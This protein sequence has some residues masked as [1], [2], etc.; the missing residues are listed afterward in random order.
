M[1]QNI[2]FSSDHHLD[3]ANIIKLCNRPFENV[4]QMN[5]VLI[6]NINKHIKSD[7]KFYLLGDFAHANFVKTREFRRKIEC[8]KIHFIMG[9]H[10][11]QSINRKEAELIF[12]TVD[13]LTEFRMNKRKYVLCHYPL[14]EWNGKRNGS[15][16]LHGHNHNNLSCSHKFGYSNGLILDVGVDTNNFVPYNLDEINL[17]M[18]NKYKLIGR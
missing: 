12:G 16:C 2:W 11:Y 18:D 5:D 9:N 3:H 10:D 13:D 8:K 1:A 14:K 4:N 7:D 17:I 15:V 6:H